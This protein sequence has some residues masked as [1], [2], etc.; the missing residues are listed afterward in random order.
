[1]VNS[2][3][4]ALGIIFPNSYDDLVPDLVAD[5]LMASIP[6]AARYRMIDFILSSMV[7]CGIDNVCYCTQKLSFPSGPPGIRT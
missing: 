6:F 2:N 7:N 4:D 3:I 1:M 5:R